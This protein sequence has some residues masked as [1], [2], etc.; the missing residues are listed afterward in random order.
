MSKSR[1]VKP[2]AGRLFREKTLS[3]SYLEMKSARLLR[4]QGFTALL[5]FCLLSGQSL[6]VF[7]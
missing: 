1:L 6:G 5:L 2:L 7:Y 3:V 4:K